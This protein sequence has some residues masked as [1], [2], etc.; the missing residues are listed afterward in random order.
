VVNK[1]IGT[2]GTRVY[3]GI[4]LLLILG[5]N[6]QYLGAS[7]L[8]KI[9]IFKLA[10]TFNHLFASVLSGPAVVYIGNRLS[11]NRLV[12]PAL[13]W[14]VATTI[15]FTILQTVLHLVPETY[16]YH[17]LFLSFLFSIQ[18]FLEQVL[19][20]RQDV[21][22]YNL[23]AFIHNTVLFVCTAYLILIHHWKNEEVFFYSFYAAIITTTLFLLWVTRKSFRLREFTFNSKIALIV[24][25]YGFWVQIN[26]FIQTLNNRL[27]LELLSKFWGD[28][29][30]GYFSAALQLAEAIWIIAKSL[31]TVQYA[32][33]AANK[34]KEF[35]VDLTML[36]SKASFIFSLVAAIVLVALPESTIG[37]C[38]GKDF[39]HVKQ[40]IV[41]LLP[42]ILFFSISLIYCHYFSGL[43][44]F[45]YNTA[46]SVITLV[47]ITGISA[48]TV[49]TYGSQ[50][51]ALAN[52]CGLFGMLVF[53]IIVLVRYE[54]I[55]A[56]RLFPGRNDLKKSLRIVK[57]YLGISNG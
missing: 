21:T 1:I 31:A 3:V 47:I 53:N 43:G 11:V 26:N 8:G 2:M 35:A 20:C 52:S 6:T 41:Y 55:P 7:I 37:Y 46:G 22:S 10:L 16:F 9:T 18:S 51:A 54:K 36:M 40:T 27:G 5:L 57:E 44:K 17:L 24:F 48:I 49:P 23:S 39:S 38:L 15:L 30:V 45:Y 4:I 12:L 19:L 34:S 25:N 32:K 42:G 50:A 29:L 28:T 33:I 56:S 14:I 13:F